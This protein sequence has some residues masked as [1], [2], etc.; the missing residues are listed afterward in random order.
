MHFQQHLITD[1]FSQQ[2]HFS[3]YVVISAFFT[4]NVCANQ[5]P[6]YNLTLSPLYNIQSSNDLKFLH[7]LLFCLLGWL[8]SFELFTSKTLAM[9][10]NHLLVLPW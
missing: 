1:L 10:V 4:E 6:L 5:L 2:T 7:I 9:L 3:F 8:C